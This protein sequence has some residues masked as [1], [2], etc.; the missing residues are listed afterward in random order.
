M[1]TSLK[2]HAHERVA[3]N[4]NPTVFMTLSLGREG[5]EEREKRR[6]ERR[7]ERE[8]EERGESFKVLGY[9]LPVYMIVD[10]F[11]Q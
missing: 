9:V 5:R 4:G 10:K 2:S 7:R 6:R 1:L 11:V 3:G 8:R